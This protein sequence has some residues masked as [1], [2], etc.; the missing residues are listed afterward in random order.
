MTYK[1]TSPRSNK[2]SEYWSPMDPTTETSDDEQ[3]VF[4]LFFSSP[5]R[6]ARYLGSMKP[7]SV[8]VS[9]DPYGE[10]TAPLTFGSNNSRLMKWILRTFLE[11]EKTCPVWRWLGRW[12]SFSILFRGIKLARILFVFFLG[13]AD[14]CFSAAEF[15][16]QLLNR[17]FIVG[18]RFLAHGFWTWPWM[19]FLPLGVWRERR[20]VADSF[21]GHDFDMNEGG[22]P[23]KF[24]LA[25]YGCFQK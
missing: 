12:C 6:K 10:G 9:Q 15:H 20:E 13:D 5:K 22:N 23:L 18:C 16:Q 7:F 3:G 14:A 25:L 1:Y 24:G 19:S 8:S 17:R 11:K 2:S 4:F 21:C